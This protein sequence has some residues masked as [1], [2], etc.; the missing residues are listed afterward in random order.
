MSMRGYVVRNGTLWSAMAIR[1]DDPSLG[2]DFK[3]VRDAQVAVENTAGK[4]LQ[5]TPTEDNGFLKYTGSDS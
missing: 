1:P 3:T 5:W 4:K 2:C